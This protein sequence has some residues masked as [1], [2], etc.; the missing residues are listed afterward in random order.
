ME[1]VEDSTVMSN[2]EKEE[3]EEE[4]EGKR[5]T[6]TKAPSKRQASRP[7]KNKSASEVLRES[8]VTTVR[9]W[10]NGTRDKAKPAMYE[11]FREVY[12]QFWAKGVKSVEP[13]DDAT[14]EQR[15]ADRCIEVGEP[16]DEPY[17]ETDGIIYEE[18]DI[19]PPEKD[20][21]TQKKILDQ[22][23]A[24]VNT[25]ER[26]TLR[27]KLGLSKL[28]K[29]DLCDVKIMP[30]YE[31]TRNA[32][33]MNRLIMRRSLGSKPGTL[34]VNDY[35]GTREKYI[36]RNADAHD[37]TMEGQT[38]H[39]NEPL[40]LALVMH[41]KPFDGKTTPKAREFFYLAHLVSTPIIRSQGWGKK[42]LRY[43]LDMADERGVPVFLE[44]DER[45]GWTNLGTYYQKNGF[46]TAREMRD[47]KT[48][49]AWTDWYAFFKNACA[50]GWTATVMNDELFQIFT[51]HTSDRSNNLWMV[52]WKQW[53]KE[54]LDDYSQPSAHL[55]SHSDVVMAEQ[56]ANE[57]GVLIGSL[58]A[59]M[60]DPTLQPEHL[61]GM[62]SDAWAH[63][64]SPETVGRDVKAELKAFLLDSQGI[65]SQS[66]T[67]KLCKRFP[68]LTVDHFVAPFSRQRGRGKAPLY[69]FEFRNYVLIA[70]RI[71]VVPIEP[72]PTID[73]NANVEAG[74]PCAFAMCILL[75]PTEGQDCPP[76][77]VVESMGACSKDKAS[78]DK[79]S[80]VF[81]QRMA[82]LLQASAADNKMLLMLR[83]NEE[84]RY[85]Y[86]WLLRSLSFVFGES[87]NASVSAHA[88][89][90]FTRFFIENITGTAMEYAL[91]RS[92]PKAERTYA[93]I[94]TG[95]NCPPSSAYWA[96]HWGGPYQ[97]EVSHDSWAK[98]LGGMVEH[99][100][101]F[102]VLHKTHLSAL[103]VGDPK[104]FG[105]LSANEWVTACGAKLAYNMARF[106]HL[107]GKF[108]AHGLS[109]RIRQ[110]QF[111]WSGPQTEDSVN[112]NY[113]VTSN[114][115]V[116]YGRDTLPRGFAR[117]YQFNPSEGKEEAS[118]LLP[119][120]LVKQA[121]AVTST[122]LR[123]LFDGLLQ[124]VQPC[125]LLTSL[126]LQSDSL[127]FKNR[128]TQYTNANFMPCVRL[129]QDDLF[130]LWAA[131]FQ[132]ISTS[133]DIAVQF[134]KQ[135]EISIGEDPTALNAKECW[136]IRLQP[137][138]LEGTA[139]TDA[140]ARAAMV[141]ALHSKTKTAL[142]KIISE[143]ARYKDTQITRETARSNLA[144]TELRTRQ[145]TRGKR[146]VADINPNGV[147]ALKLQNE[148]ATNPTQLYE[149]LTRGA[150]AAAA[151]S[152]AA[153]TMES[154]HTPHALIRT[155]DLH[156]QQQPLYAQWAEERAKSWKTRY[157]GGIMAT[158][159]DDNDDDNDDDQKE[160]GQSA[161]AI[162]RKTTS[163]RRSKHGSAS[164]NMEEEGATA[165]LGSQRPK[166][167]RAKS[168]HLIP[169]NMNPEL[170]QILKHYY[171]KAEQCLRTTGMSES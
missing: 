85:R 169:D 44:L 138:M 21:A 127:P 10:W 75:W 67:E 108:E 48:N 76:L 22:D 53:P 94:Y 125:V 124:A 2:R 165:S 170:I 113:H 130:S 115:Y 163:D 77:W 110:E 70:P 31:M 160:E 93:R 42:L 38:I 4:E 78:G 19:N 92:L 100:S 7:N 26:E 145:Q 106:V 12:H 27:N 140:P 137:D 8:D 47:T 33:L 89:N 162:K 80:D 24:K 64:Y 98:K 72:D 99:T 134:N 142:A 143:R 71:G 43:I 159:E 59:P 79:S 135:I 15:N 18:D 171:A 84:F 51:K 116:L 168:A 23:F 87:T 37:I 109:T 149:T 9:V 146:R 101:R 141:A 114:M 123:L 117:I 74:E 95:E 57:P 20:H 119:F 97:I 86:K 40:A 6:K 120:V 104:S 58:P 133:V 148:Y 52:Y 136:M 118:L 36:L 156:D 157:Q 35:V 29:L 69:E 88:G 39:P 14:I 153:D 25:P 61:I 81:V 132:Y 122:E 17:V 128:I 107:Y 139:D 46:H 55:P 91:D 13:D 56:A 45:D 68:H 16:E 50:N 166:T 105:V 155:L 126:G 30:K 158:E 5:S 90:A 62:P 34:K 73:N 83:T 111:C 54:G 102:N 3:E 161:I 154:A 82:M 32:V 112:S 66:S 152:A 121:F 28:R 151:A 131:F 164:T 1:I 96:I 150:E 49:A 103:D 11:I 65:R 63:I 129:R 41:L 60:H 167:K 144:I 147:R